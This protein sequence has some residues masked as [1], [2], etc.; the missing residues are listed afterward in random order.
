MR[1]KFALFPGLLSILLLGTFFLPGRFMSSAHAAGAMTLTDVGGLPPLISVS[2]LLGS[3]SHSKRTLQ[4]S[5]SLAL[6]NQAQLTR[7]LQDLYDPSSASYHQFLS[8]DAF[9]QQ[10]GPTP[11]EEQ[12][13]ENYLTQ[14]GFTVTQ[15]YPNHMLIDF[16]GPQSLAEQVFGV[17]INDY[18][19]PLGRDFFANGNVPTLPAYLAAF[20]TFVGGL[21]NANQ[22]YHPPLS[23]Q[24][25]LSTNPNAG[26]NCPSAG[27]G[28]GGG[29]IFGGSQVAYIPSQFAKAYN[30]DGLHNVGLQGAGQTVG[31]FELDGYSS[32]DIQAY[33]QCFG[34][35]SVPLKNVLLDGFNGQPGAG[36]IEVELDIEVIL[37]MAP[38]LSKLIVYEA[39]NTTQGFNDEL[40][41]I[42]SDKTPVISVS[43]GDC[44]TNMGQQEVQQENK[45]FQEAAAQ[46]QSIL[47]AAGDSGSSSCFQLSGQSFDTS[48]NADDPAAQPYVTS[49]GGTTL[50]LN[51][52]NSYQSE[53]VWNGG[54]FGGAGGGGIS[55]FWKLPNWQKGPGTQNS[56]SNGMRETPDVSLDADPATG[57]PVYC[58]AGSSCNGSGGG[59][60]GWL[61]VGG[62]SA[63]APMWAAMIALANQ[64]AAQHGKGVLGFL[65]PA[66]YRI[67]S[68][69]HYSS[70]FHDITPPSDPSV[71]S[72]NDEL[73]INGGAYP[74]TNAYDMATGWGTFN[75]AKLAA[76]L[77]A[78][79]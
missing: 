23:S 7:L 74:V 72:D 61:T 43:W 17:T 27:T 22:F 66:I 68:G 56:Y 69:S 10:F 39:P 46:G 60:S 15:T 31:V 41:R 1:Y 30:Y 2:Q 34:G 18:Q 37:S 11:D 13:V 32:S 44:E 12:T 20:V 36:A 73:G 77:V 26:A 63:A 25:T 9:A 3:D 4:M 71:P 75:A 55:Q 54:L 59:T 28:G 38:K 57:Y 62:T 67:A 42:V 78:G 64:E 16:S 6:R 19:D 76:D 79:K 8:V 5:V 35:G 50:T 24:S 52:N 21:D 58:T 53:H 40:A 49:V 33:A 14:E 48:L 65:N 70:D 29:G 45:Y 47:V 51:S